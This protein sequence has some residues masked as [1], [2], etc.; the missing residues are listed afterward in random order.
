[1]TAPLELLFQD[2]F[3]FQFLNDHQTAHQVTTKC[4]P[5]D[6]K[7][8]HKNIR[9]NIYSRVITCLNKKTGS[10]Y[11]SDTKKTR[12]LIDARL[13]QGFSVDDFKIVIGY[14]CHKW[15]NNS[16]MQVYL[17]PETLF[18]NNKFESYLNDANRIKNSQPGPVEPETREDLE[19]E[20]TE[21]LL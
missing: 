15:M 4:P 8:E 9:S 12:S 14:C 11:R 16:K 20:V 10:N 19:K 17:R 21:A 6:H 13:K 7:Q 1:M 5:S 18:S 3:E 2:L